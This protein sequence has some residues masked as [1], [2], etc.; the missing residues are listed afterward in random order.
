ML[1]RC[2]LRCR[3]ARGQSCRCF[4]GGRY[5]GRGPGALEAMAA[6]FG[7]DLRELGPAF[8]LREP[9]P[10]GRVPVLR[11]SLQRSRAVRCRR[12]SGPPLP[13]APQQAE[14]PL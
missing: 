5:H 4:C 11:L 3:E 10:G 12:P 6:D 9:G 14:L 7:L 13:G 2:D 8:S 1:R